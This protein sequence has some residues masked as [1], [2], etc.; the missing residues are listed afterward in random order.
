VDSITECLVISSEYTLYIPNSFSPNGD[1]KNDVFLPKGDYVKD[2]KMYIFDRWG[3][4]L[5]Y[6]D[7]LNKGWNGTVNG[8]SR[9]CQEDTYVYL[10]EVTDNLG[11]KHS[12]MGRVTLIQ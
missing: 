3:M 7:D 12:Y 10:I 2:Y 9:I 5:F 6:S 4:M 1:G 8:G 11:K